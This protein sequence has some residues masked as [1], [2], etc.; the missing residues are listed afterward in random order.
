MNTRDE[1]AAVISGMRFAILALRYTARARA[2]GKPLP[3]AETLDSE[4]DA[5]EAIASRLGHLAA[6]I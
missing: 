1:L 2:R 4:A 3:T 5:L 6:H